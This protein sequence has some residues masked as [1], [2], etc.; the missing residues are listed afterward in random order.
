M[1]PLSPEKRLQ[2][3]LVAV[4]LGNSSLQNPVTKAVFEKVVAKGLDLRDPGFPDAIL[5]SLCRGGWSGEACVH[6]AALGFSLSPWL[7]MERSRWTS[8]DHPWSWLSRDVCFAVGY[9]KELSLS[10]PVAGHIEGF[11]VLVPKNV[12]NQEGH[13]LFH[14]LIQDAERLMPFVGGGWSA[15]AV[16]AKALKDLAALGFSPALRDNRGRT[17]IHD[18]LHRGKLHLAPVF[19]TAF[20]EAWDWTDGKGQTVE[21]VFA[22]ARSKAKGIAPVLDM[23]LEEIAVVPARQ[24]LESHVSRT[25]PGPAKPPVPRRL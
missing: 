20:P 5:P 12:R 23:A 11:S 13:G 10:G 4:L 15:P 2:D 14:H 21:T 9:G 24:R 17:A 8:F 19:L 18:H 7:D 6:L 1:H 25:A 22:A 3:R 16:G